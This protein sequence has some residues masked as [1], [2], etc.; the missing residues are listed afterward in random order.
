MKCG[1]YKSTE[2]AKGEAKAN[3][4]AKTKSEVKVKTK[5]GCQAIDPV[6]QKLLEKSVYASPTSQETF[7]FQ[8]FGNGWHFPSLVA[9]VQWRT[10]L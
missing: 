4:E 8:R 5:P 3:N 2:K 1:L 9:E 6:F 7:L 10:P